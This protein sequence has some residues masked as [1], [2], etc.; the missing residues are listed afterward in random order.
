VWI[1]GQQAVVPCDF[2]YVCIECRNEPAVSTLANK[3]D[4][5]DVSDPQAH[6]CDNWNFLLVLLPAVHIS[7]NIFDYRA[8]KQKRPSVDGFLLKKGGQHYLWYLSMQ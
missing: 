2:L 7:R 8:I 4:F 6:R 3:L 5:G 1:T